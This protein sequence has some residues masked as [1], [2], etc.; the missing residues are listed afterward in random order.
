MS[1]IAITLGPLGRSL[2]KADP[3]VLAVVGLLLLIAVAFPSG[4]IID[5]L[6]FT[7]DSLIHIAP[8]LLFSV[9]LAA[10]L[11]AAGADHMIGRVFH[12]QPVAVIFAAALF[13]GLSPFCSCGVIPIIAAL[14]SLGVPLAP[15][16]AFW[17]S[18]PIMS[19]DMFVVTVGGLGL[20]FAVAKTST[21][22]GLGLFGGL[23]TLAIQRVGGMADPLRPGVGDGG[24]AASSVRK[25]QPAFWPIWQEESRRQRFRDKFGQTAWFLGKWLTLAYVLESLMV[26]YL[27]AETVAAWLGGGSA[28]AIP[29][30]AVVGAPAYL[31]GYAAIPLAAGLIQTGMAPGAALAFMTAGGATSIPAAI[32]VFALV[33]RPIFLWYLALAATGS[34]LAGFAYQLWAG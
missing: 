12:G 24:C 7:A 5:T 4:Q 10:Y 1:N 28:W 3:A 30:A 27:P 17:L 16:M 29:L 9:A 21:A 15:V 11:S 26:A 20:D 13:G 19:P 34:M 22:V 6:R 32:A 8:F 33:K 23:L 14:L 2:K 25:P 31:N 18:S